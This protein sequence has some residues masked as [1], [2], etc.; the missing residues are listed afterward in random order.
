MSKARPPDYRVKALD[1]TTDEGH[2][3]GGAWVNE[4]GSITIV[5][6]RYVVL[7]GGSNTLITLFP[8]EKKSA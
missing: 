2:S 1:K 5:L 7:P 8:V 4:N 3:V 6:D